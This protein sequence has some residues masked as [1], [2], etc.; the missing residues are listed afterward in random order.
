MTTAIDKHKLNET[1]IDIINY[2]N[3]RCPINDRIPINVKPTLTKYNHCCPTFGLL[4]RRIEI[5][6]LFCSVYFKLNSINSAC[7]LS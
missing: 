2:R 4:Q 5:Q 3:R 1:R 7:L 6:F